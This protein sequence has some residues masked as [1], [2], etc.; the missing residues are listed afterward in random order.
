MWSFVRFG[1]WAH[2]T[3]A[4][5][6]AVGVE[7]LKPKPQKVKFPSTSCLGW[8]LRC[9][10]EEVGQG[11]GRKHEEK[12]RKQPSR[13]LGQQQV[14]VPPVFQAVARMGGGCQ[15]AEGCDERRGVPTWRSFGVRHLS[16]PL[17]VAAAH[18][19]SHLVFYWNLPHT[20][21]PQGLCLCSAHYPVFFSPALCTVWVLTCLRSPCNISPILLHH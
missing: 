17:P 13:G 3:E 7:T 5:D 20:F 12:Q 16:T 6:Q 4:P 21:P 9:V 11:P 15:E 2:P 19:P 14:A 1:S 10:S 18:S 8:S